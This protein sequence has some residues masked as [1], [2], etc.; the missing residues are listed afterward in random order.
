MFLVAGDYKRAVYRLLREFPNAAADLRFAGQ[1]SDAAGGIEANI[2]EGFG[3]LNVREFRQFTRY[4]LASLGEC[5]TR[6]A[7]GADRGHYPAAACAPALRLGYRC[8]HLLRSLHRSLV[9]RS[10]SSKPDRKRS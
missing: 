2:A 1:L 9:L 5:Q 6:L 7:D 8:N 3:R 4:A 10:A